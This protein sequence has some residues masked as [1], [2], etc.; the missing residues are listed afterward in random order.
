MVTRCQALFPIVATHLVR[1]QSV[2]EHR[3]KLQVR[4]T[5]ARQFV[6]SF[7]V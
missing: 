1:I 3:Q 2:Y 5:R 6:V 4:H 7:L